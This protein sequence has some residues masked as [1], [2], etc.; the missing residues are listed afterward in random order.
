MTTKQLTLGV[1]IRDDAT[2]ANF[3]KGNNANLVSCLQDFIVG[4]GEQFIYLWSAA[5]MGCSHLLQACCHAAHDQGQQAMYIP[6]RHHAEISPQI[7]EGIEHTDLVC[8][9]D[10]DAVFGL[11]NWEEALLHLYNRTRDNN[12]RLIVAGN[13]VPPQLDCQLADL[14]SRLSWG[15]V[16]QLVDLNDEQKI[17]ALQMRAFQRGMQLSR[18]VS[19]FLLRHYPRNMAELFAVLDQLDEASLVAKRRLTIP[20]VKETLT[21]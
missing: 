11:V 10:I 16:F 8:I 18:D 3:Y 5:G 15:L 17:Q 1:Q 20:F 14:R 21:I 7:F 13:N 12:T 6:L 9:D 2:F 19:V 4:N